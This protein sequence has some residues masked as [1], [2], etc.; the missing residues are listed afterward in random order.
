MSCG[1]MKMDR[2]G[3]SGVTV[4]MMAGDRGLGKMRG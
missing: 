1:W 4:L 2:V 3:V